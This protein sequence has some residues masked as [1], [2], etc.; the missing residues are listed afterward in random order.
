MMKFD[1]FEAVDVFDLNEPAGES[2]KTQ[3]VCIYRLRD[4]TSLDDYIKNHSAALR[5]EGIAAFGNRF[6]ATRRVYSHAGIS[7]RAL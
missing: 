6:S 1:G 3:F 7:I 2:G 4:Q 5:A